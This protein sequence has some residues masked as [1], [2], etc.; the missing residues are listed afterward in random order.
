MSFTQQPPFNSAL[1]PTADYASGSLEKELSFIERNAPWLISLASAA[2]V[3]A[4]MGLFSAERKNHW[5]ALIGIFASVLSMSIHIFESV[6]YGKELNR[7]LPPNTTNVERDTH[8]AVNRWGLTLSIVF[9][10]LCVL[11]AS[12]L[13]YL[14]HRTFRL[15]DTPK[16]N[17][18]LSTMD[19][20]LPWMLH[21]V[22]L[23]PFTAFFSAFGIEKMSIG[24]TVI[25]I[26][27]SLLSGAFDVAVL[28]TVSKKN[29]FMFF[30][31]FFALVVHVIGLFALLKAF[32]A[33]LKTKQFQH[34][35]ARGLR[36]NTT[37]EQANDTRLPYVTA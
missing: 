23:S 3:A 21:L 12:V 9:S 32:I 22:S 4:T 7:V 6:S 10:V 37:G 13:G 30:L 26:F 27:M 28:R 14:M 25:A 34:D 17:H 1:S 8:Q 16:F 18:P 20:E 2:P 36:P 29:Q 19:R 15:K 5:Y 35:S 11:S 31:R 33:L 24:G